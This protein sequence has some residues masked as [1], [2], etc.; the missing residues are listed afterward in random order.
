MIAIHFI[1]IVASISRT[2][3][4]F[5]STLTANCFVSKCFP[6]AHYLSHF[7]IILQ[8]YSYTSDSSALSIQF[9]WYIKLSLFLPIYILY[10]WRIKSRFTKCNTI[11]QM[12][13]QV[14]RNYSLQTCWIDF[15]SRQTSN[16]IYREHVQKMY[17]ARVSR[18]AMIVSSFYEAT[19]QYN[20]YYTLKIAVQIYW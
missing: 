16:R 7:N 12:R 19:K 14:V 3:L 18:L 20:S 4:V 10:T 2:R 17:K 11:N 1:T 13:I 15:H 8:E 9:F 6:A 5:C